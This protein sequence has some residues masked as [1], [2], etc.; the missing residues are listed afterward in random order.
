MFQCMHMHMCI[1]THNV[2]PHVD[3]GINIIDSQRLSICCSHSQQV[4]SKERTI[5]WCSITWLDTQRHDVMIYTW[6]LLLTQR[7][8]NDIK[9]ISLTSFQFMMSQC[10]CPIY[11][12]RMYIWTSHTVPSFTLTHDHSWDGLYDSLWLSLDHHM[13]DHVFQRSFMGRDYRW[14]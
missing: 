6:C 7:V 11:I 12:Q 4:L 14:A 10:W 13:L 3:S 8:N 5:M 9:G 1:C 2:Q